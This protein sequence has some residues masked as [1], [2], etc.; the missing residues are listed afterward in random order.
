M[1]KIFLS[2]TV[3]LILLCSLGTT[4]IFTAPSVEAGLLD[5]FKP[6][7]SAGPTVS[8]N[9]L[10]AIYK[11]VSDA[12]YLLFKSLSATLRMLLD[13]EEKFKLENEIKSIESIADPKSTLHDLR[14]SEFVIVA[15]ALLR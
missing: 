8:R 15:S 11:L 5:N 7:S 1:K 12:D 10:D 6:K 2:R 9:D 13:K 3:L 4:F 14:T